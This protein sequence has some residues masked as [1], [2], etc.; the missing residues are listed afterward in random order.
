MNGRGCSHGRTRGEANGAETS[1]EVI[2]VEI[3]EGRRKSAD[4]SA[5][6]MGRGR[7]RRERTSITRVGRRGGDGFLDG[8][9]R[10]GGFDRGRGGIRNVERDSNCVREKSAF[11][12]QEGKASNST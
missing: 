6:P 9:D 7:R 8:R 11:F 3:T 5:G 12:Q 10:R 4:S 1:G 2:E